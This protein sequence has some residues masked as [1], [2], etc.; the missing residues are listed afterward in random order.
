MRA[1]EAVSLMHMTGRAAI[2]FV[3]AALAIA[4]VT[5]AHKHSPIQA[6]SMA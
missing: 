2:A 4:G 5:P 3:V 1:D 6:K